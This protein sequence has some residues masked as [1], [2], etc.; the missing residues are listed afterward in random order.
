MSVY[1]ISSIKSK[2]GI[3]SEVIDTRLNKLVRIRYNEILIGNT[4]R[5]GYLERSGY[6]VTSPIVSFSSENNLLN[7]ETENTWYTF[8][9]TNL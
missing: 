6:L 1:I 7:I 9:K 8:T 4:L 5:C 2:E 3:S